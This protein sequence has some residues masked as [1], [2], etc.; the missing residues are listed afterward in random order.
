MYRYILVP[1]DGS[2]LSERAVKEAAMLAESAHAKLLVFHVIP[3]HR[4]PTY[5]EGVGARAMDYD[6]ALLAAQKDSEAWIILAA[7]AD[8][9]NLPG[10]MVEKR[11]VVNSSPYEAILDVAEKHGCDLIVMA[12]HGRRGM[13]G[14]RLGSETQKVLTHTK[15]PVLVVH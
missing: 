7:A 10:V 11:C 3:P 6:T 12:S 15:L 14:L 1:T 8:A 13:S 5:Q 9:S 2:P 4:V